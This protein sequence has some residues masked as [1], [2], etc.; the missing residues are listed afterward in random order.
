M[1]RVAVVCAGSEAARRKSAGRNVRMGW[2]RQSWDNVY[3][4]VITVVA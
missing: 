3:L 1:E 4:A 2:F